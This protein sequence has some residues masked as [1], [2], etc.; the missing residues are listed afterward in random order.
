MFGELGVSFA[1]AKNLQVGLGV[2]LSPGW[3]KS[4]NARSTVVTTGLTYQF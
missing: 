4:D 3:N 1:P 2:I